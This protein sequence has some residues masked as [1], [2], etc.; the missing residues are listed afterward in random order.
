MGHS[1]LSLKLGGERR[2][3]GLDYFSVFRS[4]YQS[5]TLF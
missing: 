4:T 2:L 1:D 3:V 5:E